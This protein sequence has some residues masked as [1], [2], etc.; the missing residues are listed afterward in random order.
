M[1]P[2]R[3]ETMRLRAEK[4]QLSLCVVLENVQDKHNVGAVMRSCD[5][6]GVRDVHLIHTQQDLRKETELHGYKSASASQQWIR[7][8]VW[9]EVESCFNHLRAQYSQVLATHMSTESRSLYQLNLVQPTALVFGNEQR[10]ISAETLALCTGNFLIPM[11][12]FIQSLNISVACAVSLYEA[13]RQRHL[14]GAYTDQ[15]DA[16]TPQIDALMDAW[17]QPRIRKHDAKPWRY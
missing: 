15:P 3:I 17:T 16:S 4:S 9:H 7:V 10:G 2:E 8:H 14:T 12:G 1:I 6:V 11:H 13:Q 5:A